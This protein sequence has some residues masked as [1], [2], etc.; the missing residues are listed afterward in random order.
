M[1]TSSRKQELEYSDLSE[2]LVERETKAEQLAYVR[3]MLEEYG[4][5]EAVM[6]ELERRR[7]R[8]KREAK[9]GT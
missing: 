5:Y 9:H 4:S 7:I 2:R 6:E 8:R 3:A 1:G